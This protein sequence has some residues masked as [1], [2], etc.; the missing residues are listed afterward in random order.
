MMIIILI[1]LG[2]RLRTLDDLGDG[3]ATAAGGWQLQSSKAQQMRL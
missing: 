2:R 1:I 3:N